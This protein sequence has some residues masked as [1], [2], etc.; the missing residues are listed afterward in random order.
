MVYAAVFIVLYALRNA[1]ELF[2]HPKRKVVRLLK[3]KEKGLIS[4][5]FLSIGSPVSALGAAF[6][7]FKEGPDNLILYVSGIFVFLT[8]FAGRVVSLR[9]LKLNYTQD[10]RT[11]PD[12]YLVVTGI[13][14]II[15]HPI[16]L[17]YM[18]EILG[19]FIIKFNYISLAALILEILVSLYRMRV[20][21]QFLS[22]TFGS[23]FEAYRE[24][25]K[26]LIPY[27]F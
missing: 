3:G 26:R 7:L 13:Y 21:D 19:I 16:Y 23:R 20:E 25:T 15:R 14:S 8:G 2:I 5:F 6:F 11:T 10:L 17:A 27:I 22:K 4:L 24:K 1:S 9:E 12:G 18:T